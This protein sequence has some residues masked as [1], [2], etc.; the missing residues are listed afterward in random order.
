MAQSKLRNAREKPRRSSQGLAAS[1]RGALR[2]QL[3]SFALVDR[4]YEQIREAIREGVIKPGYRLVEREIAAQLNVSRTPI[5]E[6]LRLLEAHGLASSV[7]GRG[8]VVTSLTPSEIS[9]LY[10]AWESLEGMAAATAAQNA[11]DLEIDALRQI[12]ATWNTD[13]SARNLGRLNKRL[14]LAIHV[15]THNRFLMRALRTIDD[16]VSLLGF[17]TYSLPG[18]GR[19]VAIEHGAIIDAIAARDATAAAVAARAHIRRAGQLRMA[20]STDD[21][22]GLH[23]ASAFAKMQAEDGR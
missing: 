5:R 23:E 10:F 21:R 13:D 3:E 4:A 22:A 17:S 18:R 1:P 8:L 16:S 7:N 15:A 12:H 11:T 9:E 2:P 14:H 6:A 20:A 19:E